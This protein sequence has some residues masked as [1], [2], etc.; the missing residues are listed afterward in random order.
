[1]LPLWLTISLTA[2][3]TALASAILLSIKI[4]KTEVKDTRILEIS[5]IIKEGATAFLKRQY[6]AIMIFAITLFVIMQLAAFTLENFDYRIPITFLLGA[7]FSG[8]AGF[9]GMEVAIRT[10]CRSVDAAKERF[11]RAFSIAI[12]GGLVTGLFVT[13]LGLLGVSLLYYFTTN[14]NVVVGFGFG[15]ALIA[16]FGRVGG[17]IYT[18]AADIGADLVGKVEAKIPEDDPRNPAVIADQVGD[19][20]GDVAGMAADIF[21][22]YACTLI[23]ALL[24]G[25]KIMSEDKFMFPVIIQSIGILASLIA[26]AFMYRVEEENPFKTINSGFLSA[27]IIIAAFSAFLTWVTFGGDLSPFFSLLMGL[28]AII[29]LA[30]LTQYYTSNRFSPVREVARASQTGPA[31]NFLAGMALGLESTALPVIV[32]CA[33]ILIAFSFGSLYGVALAAIGFLSIAPLIVGLD[34]Y[35]PIVDNASGMAEMTGI[36][37]KVR[38]RLEELDSVGNTTKAICKS[39]AIGAAA[40]AAIALFA[41]YIEEAEIGTINIANP[42]VIAG[43]LMGAMLA[44]IFCSTLLR[45][46]SNGAFKMVE[47]VRRQFREIKGIL[48]GKVKP[49]YEN[50]IAISTKAALEGLILPGILSIVIPIIIGFSLK[51]EALGGF[52]LGNVAA[53]FPLALFLAHSGTAWDNAK[54]YIET[55]HYGGKGT[56]THAA[57]VM[58]DTVGDPFKDTAGPSLNILMDIIGTIALLIAPLLL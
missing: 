49:D 23:A 3:L 36:R 18:K 29:L 15:T 21:E 7:A 34:A 26:L 25:W 52:L 42:S 6:K 48:E 1:M 2:S 19:N 13:G 41:A 37:G 27:G 46:V 16:L 35:G 12:E 45:A 40:L 9:I 44:F 51:K 11:E 57:A 20:V 17:G 24:I 28:L 31:I 32:V 33:A 54:K 14:M 22:S 5:A 30:A 50:C 55:G 47:E 43:A 53:S 8:L 4:L 58:G 38:R 10:N 56:E 39:F